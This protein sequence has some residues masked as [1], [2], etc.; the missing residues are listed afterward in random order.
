LAGLVAVTARA[1]GPEDRQDVVL[2]AGDRRVFRHGRG[3][4]AGG[5]GRPKQSQTGADRGGGSEQSGPACGWRGSQDRDDPSG[6]KRPVRV[7]ATAAWR[8]VDRAWVPRGCVSFISRVCVKRIPRR[9]TNG[10]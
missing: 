4:A 6:R 9:E 3:G 8:A 7:A 1:M 10:A 5:S 2:K